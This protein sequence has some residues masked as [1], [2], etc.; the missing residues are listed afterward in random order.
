MDY[1]KQKD[2]VWLD[3]DPSRGKE[4]NKRRPGLVVSK[5]NFNQYTGFCF[6]CPITSTERKFDTYIKIKEPQIISGQV[7]THQLC[8]IDYIARKL[9]KIEQ[10]DILTRVDVREVLDMFIKEFE[11]YQTTKKFVTLVKKE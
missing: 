9:I 4:I 1:P 7:V 10:C 2:I 8:S 6:I 3:F 5:N 11:K